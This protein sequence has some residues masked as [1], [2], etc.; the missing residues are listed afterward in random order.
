MEILPLQ[1]EIIY[2]PVNS[3]RLG[4]SLGI[5]LLPVNYKLCSFDC[6]Y[7]HYGPT[8]EKVLFSDGNQFPEVEIILEAVEK[9]LNKNL[10]FSYLTF[11]GNG[12]PTLHPDFAIL[13]SEIH[14][15][16][17]RLRPDVKMAIL[18]NSS[19]V[20]LSCIREALALFDAPIMKLDVGDPQTFSAINR[21]VASV[22]LTNIIQGLKE[23]P[24]L[25]IQSAM[26]EGLISNVW[27][28]AHEYWLSVIDE[29]K[30][31]Q[32]Q[33][34]STD[35]PVPENGVERVSPVMLQRLARELESRL[36][37][38]VRPYWA[39]TREYSN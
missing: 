7:C 35:R 3:R 11:S 2:G 19:T 17:R 33:L 13:V 10:D 16:C 5:N 4:R 12:E 25:I 39:L 38:Y 23:L 36:G 34:Y 29:I 27:G 6:I 18:S 21:P 26:V 28:P 20:H 24:A 37:I 30:P 1:Q 8:Q 22:E 15:L 14:R 32:V 31:D 9:A